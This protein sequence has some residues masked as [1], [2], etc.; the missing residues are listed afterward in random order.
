MSRLLRPLSRLTATISLLVP[1]LSAAW[2]PYGY[3][4]YGPGY[5][6]YS[7]PQAPAPETEV[8]QPGAAVQTPTHPPQ[9]PGRRAPRPYGPGAPSNGSAQQGPGS[10]PAAHPYPPYGPPSGFSRGYPGSGRPAPRPTS[11]LR[12]AR[13]ASEEAYTLTIHLNG[14][15]TEEVEVRAQ[16]N[17]LVLSR[18]DSEQRVQQDSFDD[19]RGYTRSYSFSTGSASRRLSVPPDADLSAMSR[20]DGEN[21]VRIRIPRR[22]N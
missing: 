5:A 10:A 21:S 19:G 3:G 12:I 13:E 7:G 11:G 16:G 9:A 22:R 1:A 6:P 4:P 14:M 17:W 2:T 18:N 20:E 15:S 8:Q